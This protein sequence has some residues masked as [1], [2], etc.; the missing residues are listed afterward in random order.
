[1]HREPRQCLQP[2]TSLRDGW[3]L[4]ASCAD[5]GGIIRSEGV[6]EGRRLLQ[7]FLRRLSNQPRSVRR[8]SDG[9]QPA[10]VLHGTRSRHVR[11]AP[12]QVRELLGDVQVRAVAEVVEEGFGL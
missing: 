11:R 6:E 8:W 5:C 1:M 4:L 7:A 12:L 10:V 3:T 2:L 9:A